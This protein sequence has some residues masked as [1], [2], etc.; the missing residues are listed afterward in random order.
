[1]KIYQNIIFRSND[2]KTVNPKA[3]EIGTVESTAEK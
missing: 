3:A 1:M 2:E